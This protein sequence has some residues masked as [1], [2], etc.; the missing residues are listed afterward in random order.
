MESS[1]KFHVISTCAS[2]RAGVLTTPH[3]E[4]STP[5]FMP[6]ATQGSVKALT[7]EEVVE[8]GAGIILSNAYHLYL[9]PGVDVVREL[10]GLHNFTNWKGPILTDSGGFQAFSLGSLRKISDEGILFRS[11]I[12]GSEHLFT[13]ESATLCQETLGA[14][15]IM[16]F[17]QCIA[18]GES[19]EAVRRAMERTHRWAVRCKEAHDRASAFGR[20]AIFGIVQGGVFPE[21]RAESATYITSLDFDG[22]AVGGLAVGEAK[23]PMYD[24]TEQVARFL[25]EDKPRYLMGVGSPEDLIECVARGMDLFD[26]ALPT[27][28][29][30][31]G[32]LFTGTGRVDI[33]NRRFKEASGP[34][35]EGCDCYTC[36][37]FSAAYLHHLFKSRELLGLRLASIH[38][39]R[40]VLRLMEDMRAAIMDGTFQ[41]FRDSFLNTYRPT[42]EPARLSQKEAWMETRRIRGGDSS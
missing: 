4:V 14:D 41:S 25:P 13:P 29:A 11:H 37:D 16:C 15:I 30:R 24:V 28:V 22:Y 17:D 3:G 10:G 19:R 18:Y 38:N 39:L 27:R 42:N 7:P 36:R 5:A 12:D 35:Q 31:N 20:Q 8:V 1:L 40:F 34:L 32:A 33:T 23:A 26:C 6:V 2:A 21:L 9:R